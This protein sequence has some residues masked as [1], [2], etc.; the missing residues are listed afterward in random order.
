MTTGDQQIKW[1]Q[2]PIKKLS[3]DF[4]IL[5]PPWFLS[6]WSHQSASIHFFFSR[7]YVVRYL[8]RGKTKLPWAPTV[9]SWL[10]SSWL[11]L[12]IGLQ[13]LLYK[14]ANDN[15][16]GISYCMLPLLHHLILYFNIFNKEGKIELQIR[17]TELYG[18]KVPC[19]SLSLV[20]VFH[21]RRTRGTETLGDSS[22][23]VLTSDCLLFQKI[24]SQT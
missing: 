16:M 13:V 10:L 17:I 9:P 21:R 11:C 1:E 2:K 14:T 5:F 15:A 23:W 19:R 24:R 18:Q 7:F 6:L 22:S 3:V 8:M 4:R 12:F 20:L